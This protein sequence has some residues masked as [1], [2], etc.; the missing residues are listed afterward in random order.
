MEVD[1]VQNVVLRTR[2]PT[3]RMNGIPVIPDTQERIK[4]DMFEFLRE[5]ITKF[6]DL[7]LTVLAGVQIREDQAVVGRIEILVLRIKL[8]Q[9]VPEVE[10]D[11]IG[12]FRRRAKTTDSE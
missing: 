10:N 5:Q 7:S 9:V 1:V 6:G 3:V 4:P 12:S 8:S 2:K 11:E